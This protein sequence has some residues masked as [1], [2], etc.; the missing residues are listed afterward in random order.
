MNNQQQ[1]QEK[2]FL[3]AYEKYSDAIFRYCYYRVFDREKAKDHVQEAYCRTWKYLSEGHSVDNIRAFVY[4]IATNIIIDESRKQ[5]NVSLDAIMEKGFSPGNDPRKKLQARFESQE[6]V[7]LV[8]QLDK[9]YRDVILLKYVED[10]STK[11]ISFILRESENT[12]YVRL[13]RGFQKVREIIKQQQKNHS[14]D[15]RLTV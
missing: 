4:R 7:S 2:Q 6:I 10:L 11:E 15:A 5:K 13:S 14:Q 9:K 1:D 8:N 12:V 3:E